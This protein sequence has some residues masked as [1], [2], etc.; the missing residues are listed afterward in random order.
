MAL[1][2]EAARASRADDRRRD[3]A[4][5]PSRRRREG[6]LAIVNENM[7]GA[8]RLVSVQRGHDPRDF[9]L[10]AYG[11]AG[12]APRERRRRAHG[13]VPG[14]RAARARA[15]L[16]HR[17]P[18]RRLPRRV[19]ADVH[20]R[21]LGGGAGRGRANARR[22]RGPRR[23]VAR[24]RGDPGRRAH[25][26]LHGRHAVP[27]PGLRDPRGD[28]PRRDPL[29]RRRRARGALQPAPRAALRL[30]HARY[31]GRDRQPPRRRLRERA[32]ARAGRS[33][34]TQARTRRAPSSTSTQVW[35]E[36]EQHATT[37]YDRSKL[38][39]RDAVRRPGDRD[40]VRLDHGRAPG[41]RRP[42]STS[43]STS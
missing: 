16:R 23:R 21:A 28:R 9:A 32:E 5:A 17:R 18:R 29:G 15:A 34:S 11:G 7:A 4:R 1:D 35:F 26:H 12:P 22:A 8:L 42:R 25:G 6:I 19:R 43:T 37:I 27:R 10:V 14:G 30:P 24:E 13:L 38:R 36:G 41:L 40:G 20:P 33:A 2:V 3:G 39:P 31:G